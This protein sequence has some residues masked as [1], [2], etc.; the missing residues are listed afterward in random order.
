MSSERAAADQTPLAPRGG[1]PPGPPGGLI[2]G[3]LPAFAAD[4]LGFLT[5]CTREYGDTVYLRLPGRDVFVLN[6]PADIETVLLTQR[7]NFIKHTLLLAARDGDLRERPADE[8]GRVLAARSGGWP[9]RRFTRTASPRT[10][11]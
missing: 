8:R 6:R 1:R 7:T 2:L 11:T 4:V 10:A 5:R 9:R 3:N